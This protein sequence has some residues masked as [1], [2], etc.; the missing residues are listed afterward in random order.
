MMLVRFSQNRNYM[1]FKPLSNNQRPVCLRVLNGCQTSSNIHFQVTP[2]MLDSPT[3][4]YGVS[5]VVKAIQSCHYLDVLF[6][7]CWIGVR[8]EELVMNPE[9]WTSLLVSMNP[10]PLSVSIYG[11]WIAVA[12]SCQ[13]T[14][15]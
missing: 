15:L 13:K 5:G 6:S 9:P 8:G 10:F 2:S 1:E 4:C 12:L 14:I 3:F 11:K 7:V